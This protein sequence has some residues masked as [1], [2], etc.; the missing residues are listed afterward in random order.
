RAAAIEAGVDETLIIATRSSVWLLNQER[1]CWV[2][3]APP[4]VDVFHV[5]RST[6][7]GGEAFFG[8]MF[9]QRFSPEFESLVDDD[10]FGLLAF[11]CTHNTWRQMELPPNVAEG[12]DDINEL[13]TMHGRLVVSSRRGNYAIYEDGTWTMLPKRPRVGDLDR[14]LGEDVVVDKIYV[15][16][17]CR[18]MCGSHDDE[19]VEVKTTNLRVYADGEWT[20]FESPGDVRY[21][22]SF[23]D[24]EPRCLHTDLTAVGESLHSLA[25]HPKHVE[26]CVYDT[27]NKRLAMKRVAPP[28][29]DGFFRDLLS[30]MN[31]NSWI[32]CAFNG[33]LVLVE[34]VELVGQE[35]G[36]NIRAATLTDT[37]ETR[38]SEIFTHAFTLRYPELQKAGS[39][40]TNVR[41]KTLCCK[42]T[43]LYC[44]GVAVNP[45]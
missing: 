25:F 8:Y 32:S 14:G 6:S 27:T 45:R 22:G 31:L 36:F 35:R 2:Q 40:R 17:S 42:C 19:A 23:E 33:E 38:G 34:V 26:V 11:D 15:W 7:C 13:L 24:M 28:P 16:D 5:Y 9:P 41:A 43:T 12:A 37:Q 18:R 10:S 1:E 39:W 3:C 29:T 21:L 20:N 44:T 30:R 4:P